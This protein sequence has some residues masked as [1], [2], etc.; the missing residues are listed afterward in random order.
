MI[1]AKLMAP[2]YTLLKTCREV[3]IVPE[4]SSVAISTYN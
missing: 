3:A 4:N 2:E 1:L